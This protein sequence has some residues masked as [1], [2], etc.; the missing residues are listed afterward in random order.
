LTGVEPNLELLKIGLQELK[1]L[2]SILLATPAPMLI[3][4]GRNFIQIYNDAFRPI[5][6]KTKHPQAL[7][8]KA[9]DTYSEIWDTIKPLFDKVMSGEAVA[10][11]DFKLEMERQGVF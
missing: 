3:C 6:G 7:G 2:T 4:W 1:L 8:G 11:Q 9:S 10:F 5:N